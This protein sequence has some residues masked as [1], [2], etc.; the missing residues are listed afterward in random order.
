MFCV[1]GLRQCFT[2]LI[3][4]TQ[5]LF[6]LVPQFHVVRPADECLKTGSLP[7]RVFEGTG[8]YRVVVQNGA[9]IDHIELRTRSA[10]WQYG[11]FQPVVQLV[12]LL[13]VTYLFIVLDIIEYSQVR[14]IWTMAQTTQFFTATGHLNFDVVAGENC[15]HLPDTPTARCFGEIHQQARVKLELGLDGLQHRISLVYRVH[16]DD[17]V[18][19]ERQDDT[20]DNKQLA[21]DG[22][23]SFTTRC[24]DGIVLPGRCQDNLWQATVEMLMQLTFGGMANIVREVVLHKK[25][26]AGDW[27]SYACAA[28]G[29]RR[30]LRIKSNIFGLDGPTKAGPQLGKLGEE[31]FTG[32]F[33]TTG[34]R[35]KPHLKRH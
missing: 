19:L 29:Y 2:I 17:R 14:T 25:L 24:S 34:H 28:N 20:P 35:L 8:E 1:E 18:M 30:R 9:D 12:T 5:Y 22:G 4:V 7:Q 16:N 32:K 13:R 31:I 10:Q 27:I 3:I 15:A 6:P 21:N 11:F 33:F 23:F 26:K